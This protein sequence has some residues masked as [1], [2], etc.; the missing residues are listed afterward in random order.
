MA[1]SRTL[2]ARPPGLLIEAGSNHLLLVSRSLPSR[3]FSPDARRPPAIVSARRCRKWEKRR[4][5]REAAAL[6]QA[7]KEQVPA[8]AKLKE[9]CDKGS[10]SA[11]IDY[12]QAQA[13][14]RAMWQEIRADARQ[15]SAQGA[16]H[17]REERRVRE[18]RWRENWNCHGS[19][20][21]TVSISGQR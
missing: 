14:D 4:A 10:Q 9:L 3:C 2:F 15:E 6:I 5:K 13:N 12:A 20:Q 1:R 7:E 17:A 16:A 21:R 19:T 8:L 11:C 18:E